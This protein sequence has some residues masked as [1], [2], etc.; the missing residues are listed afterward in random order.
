MSKVLDVD[1]N[2]LAGLLTPTFLRKPVFLSWLK[3]FITPIIT[4]HDRFK[5]KRESDLYKLSHN[6]QVCYLRKVLNDEFDP[7]LRRIEITDG[8]RYTPQYIYTEAEE[9]PKFLGTMYLRD[10]SVYGDTGAD[11]LVLLPFEIWDAH[12]KEIS[13]GNYRFYDIESIVNYYRL[14]SK[15]YKIDFK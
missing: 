4:L 7:D 3:V 9:K 2:K 13:I 8:N 6:G 5:K 10:D 15:R 14:A 12:K 1:F 11:F